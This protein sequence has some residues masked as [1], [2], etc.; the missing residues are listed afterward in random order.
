MLDPAGQ[1]FQQ[2]L[3][4][5]EILIVKWFEA[6]ED[7]TNGFLVLSCPFLAFYDTNYL[8]IDTGEWPSLVIDT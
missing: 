8:A 6:I 5:M 4:V 7:N 2:M 3:Q 1:V